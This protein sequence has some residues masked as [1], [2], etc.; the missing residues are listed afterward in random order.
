MAGEVAP[1]AVA[2]K[3]GLHVWQAAEEVAPVAVPYV[4]SGQAAQLE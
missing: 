3:P 4:P 1:D 2:Y